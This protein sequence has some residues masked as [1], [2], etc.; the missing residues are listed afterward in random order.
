[1]HK[2]IITISALALFALPTTAFAQKPASGSS[3]SSNWVNNS[4]AMQCFAQGEDESHAGAAHPHYVACT[5]NGEIF[6]CVDDAHG[7][8]DCEAQD[9]QT[10]GSA[11]RVKAILAAQ[12]TH[13]KALGRLNPRP[14][15]ITPVNPTTKAQP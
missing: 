13:V 4:G 5:S 7:N 11:G 9:A 12:A 8:Q 1:M 2:S 15:N 3:C 6:C 10:A 14:A